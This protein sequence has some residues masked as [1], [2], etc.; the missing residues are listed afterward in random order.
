MHTSPQ[1]A[2]AI[3]LEQGLPDVLAS[4][5]DSGRLEAIVVRPATNERRML[6]SARLTPEG[7]IDGDRWVRDSYYRL[8]DGGSDPKCQVS[9]I[10]VRYLRQIAGDDDSLCL[11]GDNLIVDLDLSDANLCAGSRLAIGSE[12]VL[13]ISEQPH[14]GCSKF[15]SRYGKDARAFT[16][17]QQGKSL[18]LRGRYARI[19]KGG[20]IQVGDAMRKQV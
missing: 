17:S 12:V 18:H 5:D 20:V 14:T 4:P 11:A 10:N 7:G 8:P 1:Q 16:N 9:L 15:E 13:E 2:T 19:I 3:E 6:T